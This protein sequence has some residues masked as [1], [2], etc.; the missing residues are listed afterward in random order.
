[1]IE[2]VREIKS[3]ELNQ[4]LHLNKHLNPD[5]TEL[6]IDERIKGIWKEILENPNH[7][8]LGIEE[9]GMIITSCML[10]I[11][12]NLTRNA[13]P[14]ALIENVVTHERYRKKGY[15]TAVLQKAITIAKEKNCN[16]IMLMTSRKEES[17]LKFYE[18]LGF[19]RGDKTAF[20]IRVE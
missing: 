5:D 12:K 19:K 3:D 17:T 7:F 1:M 18:K 9:D 13:R 4:L 14:F 6:I 16:K 15:G 8:C 10:I 20:I 2:K 11:I